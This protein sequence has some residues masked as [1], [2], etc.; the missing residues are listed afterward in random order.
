MTL[1]E[2]VIGESIVTFH[3]PALTAFI[4]V[5]FSL[6]TCTLV[7]AAKS[8]PTTL[9]FDEPIS[10]GSPEG[11][12]ADQFLISTEDGQVLMSWTEAGAKPRSRDAFLAI[13][14]GPDG[15]IGTPQR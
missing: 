5:M 9:N 13:L 8:E 3:P 2:P 10:L 4:T 7:N 15:A 6:F 11:N 14:N 1:P 12:A